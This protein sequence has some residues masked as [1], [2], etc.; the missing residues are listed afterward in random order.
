MSYGY[1]FADTHYCSTTGGTNW[2]A[3]TSISTPC[4]LATAFTNAAA[5]DTVYLRAGTYSGQELTAVNDGTANNKITFQA[6]TGETVNFTGGICLI[7]GKDYWVINGIHFNNLTPNIN[8]YR[9]IYVNGGYACEIRNCTFDG[10][11]NNTITGIVYIEGS[12]AHSYNGYHI[13]DNCSFSNITSLTMGDGSSWVI[14]IG[15]GWGV[16]HHNTISN[17]TF[18]D[19]QAYGILIWNSTSYTQVLNC[20]FDNT[21]GY[22]LAISIC[23]FLH[24]GI[25]VHNLV[26]GCVFRNFSRHQAPG[27]GYVKAAIQLYGDYNTIRRSLFYDFGHVGSGAGYGIENRAAKNN[28]IYNNT[29]YNIYNGATLN[30]AHD[31]GCS[32]NKYYNNIFYKNAQAQNSSGY[33]EGSQINWEY[34][35]LNKASFE[36]LGHKVDYNFVQYVNTG[37]DPVFHLYLAPTYLEALAEVSSDFPLTF[38]S[39]NTER[40]GGPGFVSETGRDFRLAAGSPCIDSG[41]VVTDSDWGNLPYNGSGPDMGAFEFEDKGGPAPPANLRIVPYVLLLTELEFSSLCDN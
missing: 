4:S 27:T 10:G 30:T 25:A 29:F 24:S 12:A 2:S 5:G 15:Y 16:S 18:T 26:D 38:G 14:A 19:F 35:A 13:I 41:M 40:T 17:C 11:S 37:Y 1:S 39:H 34:P 8:G 6:Y 28:L 36:A 3:S 7:L 31:R 23:D 20:T 21:N 32:G 22:G 33:Y 9:P